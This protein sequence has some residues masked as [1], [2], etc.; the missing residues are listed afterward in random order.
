MSF[1]MNIHPEDHN[2]W[3]R[4]IFDLYGPNGGNALIIHLD[5]S[6]IAIHFGDDAN[7]Y[8]FVKKFKD[9]FAGLDNKCPTCGT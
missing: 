1:G 4:I 6:T 3:G 7:R 9:Y 5:T 8:E 2:K